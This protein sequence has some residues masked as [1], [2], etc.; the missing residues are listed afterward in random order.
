[1]KEVTVYS[2]DWC[3]YC[4]RAKKLLET[5]GVSYKEINVDKS[6]GLR[7]K[8]TKQTG[9]R[10]IPQIF[11]GEHFVGGFSELSALETSGELDGLLK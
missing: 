9:M 11:I 3:P 2:A 5:K 4:T 6:P 7:E 10:T 1:M 8:I